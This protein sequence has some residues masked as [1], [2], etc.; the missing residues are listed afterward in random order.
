MKEQMENNK[1]IDALSTTEKIEFEK[2]VN[3]KIKMVSNVMLEEWIEMITP[4]SFDSTNSK[5]KN[6]KKI[7]NN[8][9]VLIILIFDHETNEERTYVH[10]HKS[11]E[12]KEVDSFEGA[13]HLYFY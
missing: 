1:R 12:F 4:L 11:K 9:D 5:P 8:E 10:F 6:I 2:E 13:M 7:A 3:E